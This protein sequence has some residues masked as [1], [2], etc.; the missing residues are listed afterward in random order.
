MRTIHFIS[1]ATNGYIRY[2]L[3]FIST[4][5]ENYL[6]YNEIRVKFHLFTNDTDLVF[7]HNLYDKWSKLFDFEVSEIDN[8]GWPDATLLRYDIILDNVEI[9]EDD[10]Y[11][12]ID[13]DMRVISDPLPYVASNVTT[14][15]MTF[16][17][18]PGYFRGERFGE[19]VLFYW[20]NKTFILKD[21]MFFV[22]E[23]GLGTWERRIESTAYVPRSKRKTYYCGGIWFGYGAC[24]RIF[25]SDSSSNYLA[26]KEIGLTPVW[27]D[28][29]YLNR[30]ASMNRH[31]Q[32]PPSLC[33]VFGYPQMR[34]LVPLIEAVMK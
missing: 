30:F 17:K 15:L 33:F 28:E 2:W 18:H 11:V 34:G 29:S 9:V 10:I 21:L 24:F 32:C 8:F 19:K 26:D 25:L 4:F 13:S 20:S 16:V 23:G 14:G 1:I 22:R 27:H 12:Y 6:P 31:K 7:S 5:G 3:D